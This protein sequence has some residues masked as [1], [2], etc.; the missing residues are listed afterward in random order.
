MRL[1]FGRVA[2]LAGTY[3]PPS[4]KSLTHRALLLAAIADGPS[5]IRRPLLAEDTRATLRCLMAMGLST[6]ATEDGLRLTPA[7]EW[8][9]P[10][11][12]LDCGNSGTTMRLLSGLIASRPVEATLVGDASLSRRPMRR[13]AEPLRLMGATVEGD[14]PPLLVRGADLK[15]IAYRTPV[16]SAQIKSCVLL[17]GLRASGTTSVAE[18]T[19]SRDHTENMLAAMGVPVERVVEPNGTH[20]TVVR[21]ARPVGFEFSVPADVSSGAFFLVAAAL[22]PDSRLLCSEVGVNPTRTGILDVFAQ[23][24]IGADLENGHVQMGEPIADI[25]VTPCPTP[26][27]FTVS[28]ALVPRLIDEIPVLAVLATQCDGVSMVRDARELR[29]KESDRIDLVARNLRAMGATVETFD[30]GLA[31]SGPT[32]LRGTVVETEGDHRIGMAFAVAGLIADGETVIEGA[33]AIATSFPTFAEDLWD[34]TY[35]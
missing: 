17:A 20:T 26:R 13:I 28:G 8:S 7:Q 29:V 1:S 14:A 10:S 31:I 33:E 18:E 19:L 9:Q 25:R 2:T 16:P 15:G 4:D 23:C 11:E 6:E 3:R 32:K 12:P 24:G 21:A 34:L 5:R 27:P 30:D 22:L 35:V